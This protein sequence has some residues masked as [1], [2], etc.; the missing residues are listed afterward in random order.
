MLRNFKL[1]GTVLFI[2]SLFIYSESKADITIDLAGVPLSQG[3]A[4]KIQN[5]LEPVGDPRFEL[6]RLSEVCSKLHSLEHKG[7]AN[8][9]ILDLEH[10]CFDVR[11]HMLNEE[12]VDLSHFKSALRTQFHSTVRP[13]QTHCF[14]VSGKD[15]PS[16]PKQDHALYGDFLLDPELSKL[17]SLGTDC[18]VFPG[19]DQLYRHIQENFTQKEKAPSEN[20][21]FI[22]Q[23]SVGMT[24]GYSLCDRTYHPDEV[25]TYLMLISRTYQTASVLHSCYTGDILARKLVHDLQNP[26]DSAIDKLCLATSSSIG[27]KAPAAPFR[28][29]E[30]IKD[31]DD[32]ET[33]F[34]REMKDGLISSA[35]WSES[36][37]DKLLKAAHTPEKPAKAIAEMEKLSFLKYLNGAIEDCHSEPKPV[38][39]QCQSW[40]LNDQAPRREKLNLARGL[41]EGRG[42]CK[43][44]VEPLPHELIPQTTF[45][46]VRGSMA[47]KVFTSSLDRRRR[48]AC[49]E[50]VFRKSSQN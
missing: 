29:S 46:M 35:A 32:F 27:A 33:V 37:F 44:P 30:N 12:T 45:A 47:Q 16:L 48:A 23:G 38:V 10:E 50:F 24:G 28:F 22:Y 1:C 18:K 49:R 6:G 5:I 11:G 40:Y 3:A 17:R 4:E 7:L 42:Y 41:V 36:S 26:G 8:Q 19:W 2:S 43:D 13:K 21:F 31:G 25:L 34:K 14:V 9:T 39:R 15:S 20:Q